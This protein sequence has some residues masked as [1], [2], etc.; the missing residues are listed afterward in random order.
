MK[1]RRSHL[2]RRGSSVWSSSPPADAR[3]GLDVRV[4]LAALGL[5]LSRLRLQV[6]CFSAHPAVQPSCRSALDDLSIRKVGRGRLGSAVAATDSGQAGLPRLRVAR[7]R[8]RSP[9]DEAWPALDP[10]LDQAW[11]WRWRTTWT[12]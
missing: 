3:F 1:L 2:W 7:W 10:S 9:R 8:P 5:S 6:G 11:W 4:A 12:R